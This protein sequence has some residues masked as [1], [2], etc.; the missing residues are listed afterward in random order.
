M[1]KHLWV[2]AVHGGR[3]FSGTCPFCHTQ[4]NWLNAE[5]DAGTDSLVLRYACSL[6]KQDQPCWWGQRPSASEVTNVWDEKRSVKLCKHTEHEACHGWGKCV[7]SGKFNA[8]ILKNASKSVCSV[9]AVVLGG[10]LCFC[11]S[12]LHSSSCKVS[13]EN[14]INNKLFCPDEFIHSRSIE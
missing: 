5:L 7:S 9:H 2:K 10:F 13:A 14:N 8:I 1:L 11:V 6:A 4:S 3:H 12:G